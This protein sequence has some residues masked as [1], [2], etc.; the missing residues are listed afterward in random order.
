MRHV[1]GQLGVKSSGSGVE[2]YYGVMASIIGWKG[3][4]AEI[5]RLA[6]EILVKAD[7]PTVVKTGRVPYASTDSV[8]VFV[9]GDQLALRGK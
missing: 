5:T 4:D 9:Q 3:T 1:V 6:K 2:E 7:I 8:L